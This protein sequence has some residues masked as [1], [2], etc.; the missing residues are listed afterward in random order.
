MVRRVA[1][2]LSERLVLPG[3]GACE[4]VCAS[5]LEVEAARC[6]VAA[7]ARCI[8]AFSF[9]FRVAYKSA[10]MLTR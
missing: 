4:V 6:A 7:S 5:T 1:G 9:S 8:F 3:A 2:A 10:P